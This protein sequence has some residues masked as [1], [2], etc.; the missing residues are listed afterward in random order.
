[1]ARKKIVVTGANGYIAS[2][3]GLYNSDKFDVVPVTRADVDFSDPG[4]VRDYFS[5][6]DYDLLFHTAAVA[7][8]AL[9]ESDPEMTRRVNVESPK[10]LAEVGADKGARL[11]FITTEQTFNAKT[12][13]APFAEDAEPESHS[14]YGRQKSEVDAWLAGS[15]IDYVTLRLS[16]MMGL[17]L[18]GVRPSPNV[19]LQVL[20]A[21][22]TDTPASFKVHDKRCLTYAQKLA[23]SFAAVTELPCGCYNF[24]AE[25]SESVYRCARRLAVAFGA[26]GAQIDRLV[27]PDYENYAEQPRDYRLDSAKIR[28]AGI[29][30]G[31]FE[32]N[33]AAMMADFGFPKKPF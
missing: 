21:L 13:G 33:V 4:H 6:M 27:L 20:E 28:A 23:D 12:S 2:L 26:T 30:P 7:S 10:A 29:D 15:D 1:M 18:H 14:H 5:G 24:A 19:A 11:V 22:R 8:T 17:P 25:Q 9:C 32:D 16:W 3:V 31:T